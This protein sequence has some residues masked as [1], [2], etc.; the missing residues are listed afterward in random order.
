MS[1][2]SQKELINLNAKIAI[3]LEHE[4][5]NHNL[6]KYNCLS[7]NKNYSNKIDEKSRKQFKNTFKF[8][9]NDINKFIWLLR[10]VVYPYEYMD[11]WKKFNETLSP[12]KEDFYSN[13]NMENIKDSNYNHAKRVCKGFEIINLSEYHDL[14]LKS[15]TLLLADVSKNFRKMCLEIYGL[16]LAKIFSATGLA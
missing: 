12:G 16:H 14:Y 1:I 7:C 11:D 4:F 3:F 6:I 9:N 2:I 5:L 10:K 8:S 13:L 15:D